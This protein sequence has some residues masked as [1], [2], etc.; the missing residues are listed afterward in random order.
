M[1]IISSAAASVPAKWNDNGIPLRQGHHIEWQRAAAMDENGYTCIVWSDTRIGD[2][3]VWAQLYDI[4]G[5]PQ[6]TDNGMIIS[7]EAIRQEDPDICAD[8]FGNFIITW[9]DFRDDSLGDVWAQKVDLQGNLLWA[10]GG[11]PLSRVL[12]YE[13]LTLHTIADEMGGAMVLWH[14]APQAAGI[15]DLWAQH[16]LSDGTIDPNWP[17]D[18]KFVAKDDGDQGGPGQQTVDTDGDGGII[19]AWTD[20]RETGNLNIYCQRIEPDGTLTWA[21]STGLLVCNAVDEQNGVKLAPDGSGGAY[22]VWVDKRNQFVT[23]TDLYIQR[24][25]AT[26]QMQFAANGI[27]VCISDNTQENQRIANDGSGNAVLVWEDYRN[28]P[29]NQVMDIYAAKVSP[30]G[31]MPWGTNGVPV[32]TAQEG[33]RE[34]RINTAE[35]GSVVLAWTDDRTAGGQE[36]DVY[37]QKLDANGAVVWDTDGLIVSAYDYLQDGALV[38]AHSDGR[39]LIAWQDGRQGSPGVFCQLYN[40]SGVS[41]LTPGGVVVT[42]GIDGD[43]FSPA[44]I[45]LDETYS[46]YLVVWEDVNYIYLGGFIYMQIFGLTGEKNLEPNGRPVAIEYNNINEVGGGQHDPQLVSDGSD[47]A[48]I[49]WEDARLANASIPQIYAQ[50]VNRDGTILWDSSGKDLSL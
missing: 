27:P 32:C 39:T 43:A 21:D 26:G 38:R 35:A 48:I 14:H 36:S 13:Q 45:K 20:S 22:M 24:V 28:D 19:V 25:N 49:C 44:I 12:N 7:A 31:T 33:Q 42:Y 17:A 5:Q 50:R 3:D 37:A 1:I 6:W 41:Q 34:I 29:T 9:V 30:T 40:P 11:V 16:V 8:G 15:G 10:S 2:R 46:N 4:N 47:G 23:R 18:G